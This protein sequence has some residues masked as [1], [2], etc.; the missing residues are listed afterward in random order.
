MANKKPAILK[1][2]S[3]LPTRKQTQI[4]VKPTVSQ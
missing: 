3:V 2:L 1:K 4:V